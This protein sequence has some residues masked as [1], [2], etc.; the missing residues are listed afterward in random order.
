MQITIDNRDLQNV[1]IDT[2]QMLTGEN[3]EE[4]ERESM[5]EDGREDWE[6]VDITYDHPAIVEA[7]AHASIATVLETLKGDGLVQNIVYCSSSSPRFYNYTTDSYIAE[8]EV[9]TPK[10]HAYIASNYDEVL[11]KAQGYDAYT[12]TGEVS[13]DN[14][15]HAGLCHYIDGIINADD[16]NMAMWEKENECYYENQVINPMQ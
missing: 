7:L 13:K 3:A 8:Y 12:L 4:Y 10:L 2:Y 16:Y 6:T 1:H 11:A 5:R 14:L 9:N 15:A